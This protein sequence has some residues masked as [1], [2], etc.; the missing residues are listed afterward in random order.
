MRNVLL[1]RQA[2]TSLISGSSAAIEVGNVARGNIG[3]VDSRH[4]FSWTPRNHR[5]RT[6]TDMWFPSR[7]P[8]QH[9]RRLNL[10][11]E[12]ELRPANMR[13]IIVSGIPIPV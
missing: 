1:V 2:K 12:T 6:D 13:V 8:S 11:I 10:G 9:G 4:P 3:L 7:D 5:F